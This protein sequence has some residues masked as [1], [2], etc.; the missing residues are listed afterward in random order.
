MDSFLLLFPL[1]L[2]AF[3][4]ESLN[5]HVFEPRYKQL[6]RD[7]LNTNSN[8]GI[9]SFVHKKI[10]YGTEVEIIRVVKEYEDG[11]LDI[12]TKGKRIFKV[13]EF[14]N[15]L[16]DKL[17]AGGNIKFLENKGKED[18]KT[19]LLMAKW[20]KELYSSLKLNEIV[21]PETINSF[22]IGHKVGLSIEE[23]YQLIKIDNEYER[24][25]FIINHLKKAVPIV[26]EI[27]KTKSRIN[28]NGHFKH[29]DPLSF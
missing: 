5:L 12:I 21:I 17:Y 13:L 7:A 26:K 18:F 19:K 4:N 22:D 14:I 1:N 16:P 15:P 27:E 28:M 6:I 10:E 23:E 24:Q 8:F 29:L 2:V 3:P 20:V 11:R 25:R 9:P